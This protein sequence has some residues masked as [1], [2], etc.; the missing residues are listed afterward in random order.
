MTFPC[1]E[2]S[3]WWE[4]ECWIYLLTSVAAGSLGLSWLEKKQ[5]NSHYLMK[6]FIGENYKWSIKFCGRIEL[7][8]MFVMFS[9][10]FAL[11]T[12]KIYRR[13]SFSSII[14]HGRFASYQVFLCR[15]LWKKIFMPD[16]VYI[17]DDII[18]YV[19]SYIDNRRL[20]EWL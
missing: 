15:T 16:L 19:L 5:F 12:E 4:W 6:R 2:R 1:T 10:I 13:F 3:Y 9:F 17:K 18:Y 7:F 20:R 11:K 14:F 8:L